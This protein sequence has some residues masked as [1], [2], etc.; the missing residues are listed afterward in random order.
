MARSGASTV[1]VLL[2]LPILVV[3][4]LG[5]VEIMALARDAH[6]LNQAAHSALE[7]A[8]AGGAPNLIDACVDEACAPLPG[9]QVIRLYEY[10]SHDDGPGKPKDWAVLVPMGSFNNAQP[11]DEVRVTLRYNHKLATGRLFAAFASDQNA[12]TITIESHPRA[13]RR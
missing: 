1:E 6:A 3:L 2:V 8:A 11:G 9:D 7:C 12:A 10:R 5:L 4:V 13:V